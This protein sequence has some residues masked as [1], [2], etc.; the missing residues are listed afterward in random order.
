MR[1]YSRIF[2][3]LVASITLTGLT[4]CN[5]QPSSVERDRSVSSSP[6]ATPTAMAP[7]SP[8]DSPFPSPTTPTAQFQSPATSQSLTRPANQ[9][10]TTGTTTQTTNATIYQVDSQCE[11]FVS[12]PVV[13]PTTEPME[14]AV[15]QVLAAWDT[16]DFSLAG[17]R[18]TVDEDSRTATVDL[19]VDPNSKRRLTSLSSCEQLALFGALR[20]TLTANRQ[21]NID[22]VR[23]TEQGEE[24]VL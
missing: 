23:F 20:K 7:A 15:K 8:S 4:S 22:T 19:R 6:T 9:T 11:D 21:W 12:K 5:N 2:I 3:F 16:A 13:L 24:V 1:I 14:A 10:R 17:Y 18:V